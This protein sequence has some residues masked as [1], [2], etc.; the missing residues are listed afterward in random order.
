MPWNKL[1]FVEA[2]ILD[3]YFL[4]IHA[5]FCRESVDPVALFDAPV[6]Q[7][8]ET[9]TAEQIKRTLERE[10]SGCDHLVLW[11][12]CDREGEAIGFEIIDICRAI[13][14]QL[15]GNLHSLEG[16]HC[17]NRASIYLIKCE[18]L[19]RRCFR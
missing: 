15:K 8:C 2:Q 5:Y 10:V 11:T 1:V 14:L 7:R 12:D 16:W 17:V 13:K 6:V 18:C 19:K 3:F 4:Y 9:E